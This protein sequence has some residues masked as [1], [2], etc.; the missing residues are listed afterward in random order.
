MKVAPKSSSSPFSELVRRYTRNA[1]I[2]CGNTIRWILC[3]FYTRQL[4]IYCYYRTCMRAFVS[5]QELSKWIMIYKARTRLTPLLTASM[6]T[7]VDV[8]YSTMLYYISPVG[9]LSSQLLS[10]S[11]TSSPGIRRTW[12]TNGS[13]ISSVCEGRQS[14]VTAQILLLGGI[15]INSWMFWRQLVK[16]RIYRYWR[17]KW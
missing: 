13:G 6:K 4:R 1:E 17:G 11:E 3:H 16:V 7:T 12:H 15:T 10:I 9:R 14:L 2:C 8:N 5:L